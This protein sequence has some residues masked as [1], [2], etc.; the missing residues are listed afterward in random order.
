MFLFPQNKFSHFRRNK[1][2]AFCSSSETFS[3]NNSIIKAYIPFSQPYFESR[4]HTFQK[5][6]KMLIILYL[7]TSRPNMCYHLKMTYQTNLSTQLVKVYNSLIFPC[8]WKNLLK[9]FQK[10]LSKNE[11]NNELRCSLIY[12]SLKLH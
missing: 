12:L 3:K 7:K 4:D 6:K 11:N 10:I 1:Y 9:H 2:I 5:L 8:S